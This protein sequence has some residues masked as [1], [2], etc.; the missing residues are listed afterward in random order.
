MSVLN[1]KH[2]HFTFNTVSEKLKKNVTV[3]FHISWVIFNKVW[4]VFNRNNPGKNNSQEKYSNVF[5]R[6]NKKDYA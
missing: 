2:N 3:L 1:S 4:E 6:L 5:K